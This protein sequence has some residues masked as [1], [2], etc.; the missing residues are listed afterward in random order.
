[1]ESSQLE[2]LPINQLVYISEKLMKSDFD[3]TD[4]YLDYDDNIEKLDKILPY[5][6][7]N[8]QQ[9]DL[10]FIAKFI[11]T[12]EELILSIDA[13]SQIEPLLEKFVVP[14]VG[15]YEVY[16][17]IWGPAT[18]TEHYKTEWTTYDKKWVENSIETAKNENTWSDYDGDYIEH[19]TDNWE[20][21]NFKFNKISTLS[22][23]KINSL[24]KTTLLELRNLIDKKLKNF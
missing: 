13:P 18:F 17:E 8:A 21:D 20:P 11:S 10:D 15:K 16:Y 1:M 2:N 3:Y 22:E 5:F 4:P 23:E 6:G 9:I 14:Q 12:N 24:E 19:E 7:F